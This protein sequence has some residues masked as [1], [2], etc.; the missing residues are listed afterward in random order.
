M[1]RML[2]GFLV[3]V[4]SPSGYAGDVTVDYGDFLECGSPR[5]ITYREI[6]GSWYFSLG[7]KSSWK[8]ELKTDGRF[9]VA[10]FSEGRHVESE[11]AGGE[12][13]LNG[14]ILTLDWTDGTI[15]KDKVSL[16]TDCR[17][18]TSTTD[19]GNTSFYYRKPVSPSHGKL[20]RPSAN[21][22]AE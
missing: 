15:R 13:S 18:V 2:W 8:M 17:L 11:A 4:L 14:D 9:D 19:G 3:I 20:L 6:L 7:G 22:S 5:T 10:V 21:A 1:K 16:I 12:W